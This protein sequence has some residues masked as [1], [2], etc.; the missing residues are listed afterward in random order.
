MKR[1]RKRAIQKAVRSTRGGNALSYRQ[2]SSPY[3]VRAIKRLG[4]NFLCDG[5][6]NA[7]IA[8]LARRLVPQGG[9]D[10]IG[11]GTG[12]LTVALVAENLQVNAIETDIR[13]LPMLAMRLRDTTVQLVHSDVRD[14]QPPC[15]AGARICVGNIPYALT[16]DILLWLKKNRRCYQ[17][18]LFTVQREVADRLVAAPAS[19]AY[20]RL[21]ACLQLFFDVR[22][23]FTIPRTCFRPRPRV[24]SALLSLTPRAS[25][26]TSVAQELAFEQFTQM[27]FHM[28]R[29]TLATILK[30]HGIACTALTEAEKR[31]RV[32]TFSPPRLLVLMHK[33]EFDPSK[34]GRI[35]AGGCRNEQL[36]DT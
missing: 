10:E 25:P 1:A 6:I 7:K 4:Q 17:H 16:T 30:R 12:N 18:A 19:K 36:C 15:T 14:W 5:N 9:C 28:R 23:H 26:C 32:E 24:D 27:L 3:G 2:N 11:A 20:G 31:A 21:S 35:A 13:L 34:G 33:L 22:Q 29:K 8:R